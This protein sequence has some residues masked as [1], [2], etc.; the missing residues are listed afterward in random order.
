MKMQK[1]QIFSGL[2]QVSENTWA[3]KFN[4]TSPIIEKKETI[5]ELTVNNKTVTINSI[6]EIVLTIIMKYLFCPVWIVKQW[7]D[8]VSLST[9]INID[10]KLD[11][12]VDIGLVWKEGS[13]TG[14]YF[15]PTYLMFKLFGVDPVPYSTIPFNMLTH[16]IS[17]QQCMFDIM[18]GNSPIISR[19]RVMP[20]ISELGFAPS[21]TGT[22]ALSEGDFRFPNMMKDSGIIELSEAENKIVE[23]IK[24]KQPVTQELKEFKY[25]VISRKIDNTGIVRKDYVFHIPDIVIPVVRDNGKPM[26]IAVEVELTNKRVN[27]YE[28]A[29]ERYKNN[30][31]YCAC[32]WLCSDSGTADSIKRAYQKIGG[33]GTCRT[34]LLEFKIPSPNF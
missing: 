8:K 23:G 5:I 24:N 21:K 17:E 29:L 4:H 16:T 1:E 7:Y 19:E 18:S 32:Y 3:K 12:W 14:Q 15:R 10:K 31:R 2:L 9:N 25:F 26:S 22:N 6:D 27:G 28:S 13:V 20:R 33:T 30:N 34:V 11:D